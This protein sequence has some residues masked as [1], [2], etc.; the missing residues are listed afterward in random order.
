MKRLIGLALSATI[1]TSAF[2]SPA[3]AH[4]NWRRPHVSAPIAEG[5]VG[6]LSLAIGDSGTIYVSQA[7]AGILSSIDRHGT[8]DDIAFPSDPNAGISGVALDR[9]R[10]VIFTEAGYDEA[11]DDYIGLVR[12]VKRDGTVAT[13]GDPGSYEEAVNPDGRNRYGFTDLTD[14]CA[15]SVPDE[16]GG[17]YPMRGVVDSNAYS[18]TTLKNGKIVV[19]DAGG[20]DLVLIDRHGNA[21]TLTVFEPQRF[22]VPDAEA[23]AAFGLPDCVVGHAYGFDPVPTDVELG[24]D[25]MLYVSLLPGGPEDASAGARGKVVRV[26]PRNGHV[27]EIASGLLGAVDLAVADDGTIYVAEL[28]GGRISKVVRSG[29]E[30]VVELNEP[31]AIEYSRGKLY[32]AINVLS[33]DA[34]GAPLGAI[35]KVT[36]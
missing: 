19:A 1:I 31:G 32:V 21:S 16:V 36:P 28:F 30:T 29:L 34:T 22:V 24:P 23:A 33:F 35:V 17:G 10:Q 15:K 2:S 13:I 5:L 27:R 14:E 3:L 9:R 6:P 25:G 26:N 7:F 11:N 12:R 4:R 20:N 8:V 18:L